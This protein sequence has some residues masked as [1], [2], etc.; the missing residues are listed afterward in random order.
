MLRNVLRVCLGLLLAG[1]LAIVVWSMAARQPDG[2]CLNPIIIG[3]QDLDAANIASNISFP[4]AP[5][6]ATYPLFAQDTLTAFRIANLR[7]KS[8]TSV[9]DS[10]MD[11]D[12][13][14]ILGVDLVTAPDDSS[15]P[16]VWELR[17]WRYGIVLC[18]FVLDAGGP[19]PQ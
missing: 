16:R 5:Y 17:T 8:E 19:L 10:L 18:P 14:Y 15:K 3:G 11:D 4:G 2:S 1:F 12:P 7:A 13:T 6:R 9:I